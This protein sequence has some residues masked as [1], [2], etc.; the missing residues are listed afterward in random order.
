M[1]LLTETRLKEQGDEALKAEMT[2]A[3]YVLSHFLCSQ[4]ICL[5]REKQNK[6]KQNKTK[7]TPR[8]S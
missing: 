3:G 7:K 8:C 1:M 6:T 2:P 4:V 5:S